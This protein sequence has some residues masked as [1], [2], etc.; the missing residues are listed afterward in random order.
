VLPN[1]LPLPPKLLFRQASPSA[2]KL[3]AATAL[4]PLPPLPQ[5]C[6]RHATAAY[7][8]KEK[9]VILLTNLFFTT[10]VTAT[11]SDDSGFTTIA[12]LL[13]ASRIAL[14]LGSDEHGVSSNSKPY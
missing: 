1:T 13:F 11:S 2:I 14:M 12:M 10:M 3:A 5:R 8:I 9:Y 4:P 7:K 6:H